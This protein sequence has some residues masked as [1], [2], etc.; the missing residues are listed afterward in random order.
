MDHIPLNIV[1]FLYGN[2]DLLLFIN[3]FKITPPLIIN[4]VNMAEDVPI[5][6]YPTGG[7]Y[8]KQI[9]LIFIEVR[10]PEI[11]NPGVTVSNWE[12][13]EKIKAQSQPEE[14]ENLRVILS[15]RELIRFE[16]EFKSKR[17]LRKCILLLNGKSLKLK[18]FSDPLKMK[19]HESDPACPKKQDWE[20]YFV[21]K[22]VECFDEGR[23]GERPDTVHV[24]GLPIR[25]FVSTTSGDKPCPHMVTQAF[26]K[27]G[28]VRQVA[29]TESMQGAAHKTFSSFGP[30]AEHL[31]FEAYIQ[32]DRYQGFCTAM[33]S[34]SG[35]KL[36]RLQAGGQ[37]VV[38][39][40]VDYDR[41]GFLSERGIRKRMHLEEKRRRE[42]EEEERQKQEEERQK[43][44]K[45]LEELKAKVCL[46]F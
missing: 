36:M 38:K 7:L 12:V 14:Y 24:Q 25:W 41:T 11:R 10:L 35:V 20:D 5:S 31:N 40:K 27:F 26:Q 28:K 37:A 42:R 16:G 17:A 45:R 1:A 13:M 4:L 3:N 34:L 29:F 8:L 6:F 15:T 22:G 39:L 2:N 46:Y 18:G 23:P 9:A 33:G 44:I 43:E 19:A 32:Y 21:D 30:G